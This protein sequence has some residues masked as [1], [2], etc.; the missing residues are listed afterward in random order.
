MKTK[1]SPE[2]LIKIEVLKFFTEQGY[3]V[4]SVI[5]RLIRSIDCKTTRYRKK[6]QYIE[7]YE[8]YIKDY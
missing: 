1:Q 7:L 4:Y 6:Q 3:D 2:I 5:Q 8:K